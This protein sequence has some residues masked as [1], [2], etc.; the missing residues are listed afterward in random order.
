MFESPAFKLLSWIESHEKGQGEFLDNANHPIWGV[1]NAHLLPHTFHYYG[2]IKGY[3]TL[4][5][6]LGDAHYL[7][8]AEQAADYLCSLQKSNGQYRYDTFEFNTP[9]S[10]QGLTLIHNALPSSALLE[11]YK[12][13]HKQL[14]LTTAKKNILWFRPQKRKP[15]PEPAKPSVKY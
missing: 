9:S 11:L 3:L 12:E 13:T 7:H 8:K 1:E 6:H 10:Q 2:I 14:Y 5:K 15:R 4:Y